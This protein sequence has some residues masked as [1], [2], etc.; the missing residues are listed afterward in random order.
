MMMKIIITGKQ[1]EN[2]GTIRLKNI[3]GNWKG[4]GAGSLTSH[5]VLVGM[6]LIPSSPKC[7]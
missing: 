3:G 4:C 7:D 5:Q 1:D 6:G 2:E